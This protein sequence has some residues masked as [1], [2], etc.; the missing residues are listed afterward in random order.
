MLNLSE[1]FNP[2][3]PKHSYAL[4]YKLETVFNVFFAYWQVQHSNRNQYQ[5]ASAA[6]GFSNL[7]LSYK[8]QYSTLSEVSPAISIHTGTY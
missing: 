6:Q 1:N 2:N 7:F 5:C 3:I 4:A 8:V